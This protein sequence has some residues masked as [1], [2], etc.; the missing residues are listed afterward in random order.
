M[1][2]VAKLPYGYSNGMHTLAVTYNS[3]IDLQP[4]QQKRNHVLIWKP[5]QRPRPC[6][7]MNLKNI[8]DNHYFNK[9]L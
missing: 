3:L 6:E 8:E 4:L 1:N 2:S 7:V 5:S 9:Q